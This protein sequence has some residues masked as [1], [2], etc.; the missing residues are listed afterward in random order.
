MTINFFYLKNSCWKKITRA[1]TESVHLTILSACDSKARAMLCS[2]RKI[3]APYKLAAKSLADFFQVHKRESF[4]KIHG[5]VMVLGQR[6]T[7]MTLKIGLKFQVN[8]FSVCGDR[9]CM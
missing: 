9:S 7:I 4:S 6:R 8:N 2:S 5:G 1:V 3:K